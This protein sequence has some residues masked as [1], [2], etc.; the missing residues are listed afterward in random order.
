MLY[1][2]RLNAREDSEETAVAHLIGARSSRSPVLP[3][4][5]CVRAES[6]LVRTERLLQGAG[7]GCRNSAQASVGVLSDWRT[8]DRVPTMDAPGTAATPRGV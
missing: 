1:T 8:G 5:Q 3:A 6:R 2:G 4:S 7:I